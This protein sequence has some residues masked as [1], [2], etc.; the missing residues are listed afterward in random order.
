MQ[1]DAIT[2]VT[3]RA[4]DRDP[5]LRARAWK[6][7]LELGDAPEE[8]EGDPFDLDTLAPGLSSVAEL[9]EEQRDEEEQGGD[10]RHA[11]VCI[12]GE[13]RILIGEDGR[14]ERPDDQGEDDRPTPV[15]AHLHTGDASE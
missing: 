10:N 12:L 9:V 3:D 6:L 14:R 1:T 2:A 5:E 13:T 8:P 7:A 11:K 15:E 4:G